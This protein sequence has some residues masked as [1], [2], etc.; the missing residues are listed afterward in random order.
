MTGNAL[1]CFYC[2]Y[3][4]Y[5]TNN[6]P[7]G[8]M[9]SKVI[10]VMR[11]S[12][13]TGYLLHIVIQQGQSQVI[14]RL[15]HSF[16][17]SPLLF[18][19]GMQDET[20]KVTKIR[21]ILDPNHPGESST[22]ITID[23]LLES[24]NESPKIDV[25]KD[26]S[27]VSLDDKLSKISFPKYDVDNKEFYDEFVKRL[28]DLWPEVKRQCAD[29]LDIPTF[30]EADEIFR[31]EV[32]SIP[33]KIINFCYGNFPLLEDDFSYSLFDSRVQIS[34]QLSFVDYI[35]DYENRFWE[36]VVI[37][38]D[39]IKNHDYPEASFIESRGLK[40]IVAEV[41]IAMVEDKKFLVSVMKNM[42]LPV[43]GFAKLI[44]EDIE[45]KRKINGN[46][47]EEIERL[48]YPYQGI[49]DTFVSKLEE[50]LQDYYS[51]SDSK[52]RKR[53]PSQLIK[54]RARQFKEI[55]DTHLDWT[56]QQVADYYTDTMYSEMELRGDK[57]E[58]IDGATADDVRNAYKAMGW[59]WTQGKRTK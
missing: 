20:W 58:S 9:N 43:P 18:K 33:A 57:E 11:P 12:I 37:T 22:E 8:T 23:K 21:T 35:P 5:I 15:N 52:N 29:Y 40:N 32:Y 3:N 2:A 41:V 6:K 42:S 34:S 4:F 17:T 45:G 51:K 25:V 24:R 19:Y 38:T 50:F 30:L 48:P 27:I 10:R 53:G 14:N 7:G 56:Q 59:A 28:I 47:M 39:T 44:K 16:A 36:F 1:K 55:K 13:P 46:K 26:V 31:C 49:I 54:N